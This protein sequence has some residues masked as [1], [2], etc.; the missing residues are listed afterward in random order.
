MFNLCGC[1]QSNV[2][3]RLTSHD[4]LHATSIVIGTTMTCT[5][6]MSWKRHS[7]R[8]LFVQRH[9][10][11]TLPIPSSWRREKVLFTT[12]LFSTSILTSTD[13]RFFVVDGH[14]QSLFLQRRHLK[15]DPTKKCF[16]LSLAPLI[17][18]R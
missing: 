8:M 1:G 3:K 6:M 16:Y 7:L 5:C 13:L 15:L 9:Q 18:S 17:V 2:G 12:S 14:P 11:S 4:V 10:R